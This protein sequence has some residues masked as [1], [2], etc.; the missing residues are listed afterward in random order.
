MR[1][2]T[3][4][5][6]GERP[7][8]PEGRPLLPAAVRPLAAALLAICVAVAGTLGV[9]FAHQ[10]RPSWLD[11]AVD[12]RLHASL[13]V[14]PV[15]L[16]LLVGLG[17]PTSVTEMTAALVLGCLAT[18]RW[19]AAL[20]AAVAVSA[21]AASTE[22]VLKPLIDRRLL[23]GLSFPSGH[24][25]GAVAL[26]C[27]VAV[28]LIDPVRPRRPAA[29]RLLLTV[30]VLGTAAAVAVALVSLG[31]HYFTDTVG[32]AAVAAAVVLAT[33]LVLDWLSLRADAR[34]GWTSGAIPTV[35]G[36]RS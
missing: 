28:L 32:G 10:T 35:S 20:L 6:S 21:A 5:Q 23:G 2:V 7:P 14:H 22:L 25:T 26:A 30:I 29:W 33:A 17:N 13:G 1:R 36:R 9:W 16:D 3:G 31:L 8:L 4:R 24:T 11:T 12:S 27:S 34:P 18:R 15:M 19:R